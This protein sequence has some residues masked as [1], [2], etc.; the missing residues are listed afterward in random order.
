MKGIYGITNRIYRRN[1][2]TRPRR[3]NQALDF[4]VRHMD[5]P[6]SIEKLAVLS[7]RHSLKCQLVRKSPG[8]STADTGIAPMRGNA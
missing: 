4:I 5:R 6:C 8:R 3:L 1:R 7:G 2:V